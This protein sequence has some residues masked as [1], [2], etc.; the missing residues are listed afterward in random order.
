M[1]GEKEKEK[2]GRTL[3]GRAVLLTIWASSLK[4]LFSI[5]CAED[6]DCVE[7]ESRTSEWLVGTRESVCMFEGICVLCV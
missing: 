3:S 1:R 5:V 7:S 4:Q 6:T 2:G